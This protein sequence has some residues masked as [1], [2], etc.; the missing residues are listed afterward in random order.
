MSHNWLHTPDYKVLEKGKY[1]QASASAL[2]LLQGLV[3]G[4]GVS[5]RGSRSCW[6]HRGACTSAVHSLG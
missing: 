2:L 6:L 4:T 3:C 1:V 5:P